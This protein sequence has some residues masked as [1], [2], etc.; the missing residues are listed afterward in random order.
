MNDSF[1]ANAPENVGG[2]RL[3]ARLLVYPPEPAMRPVFRESTSEAVPPADV[4]RSA[5]RQYNRKWVP[6]G[7]ANM[8]ATTVPIGIGVLCATAGGL[9]F[10]H[11][12]LGPDHYVPFIAMSRAGGWSLM[13]TTVITILCG[14]GHVLS[15]VVLGVAGIAVGIAVFKLETIEGLRGELAG[16]LLLAFGLA[17]LTWGVHRAV[18]NRPHTHRH[19]HADGTV[20]HHTHRHANNHAHAHASPYAPEQGGPGAERAGGSMTP[21]ILF[22]IFVFGPCEP[23]I[24]CV[25]YP[26]AQGSVWGVALVTLVFGTITLATMTTIVVLAYLGMT[27]FTLGRFQRYSHAAA[28]LLLVTCGAA[29]LFGL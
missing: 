7:A 11:T 17:Y 25:M 12:L 23:L 28:G 5:T 24:P 16:W 26:A 6:Y 19:A 20:H 13:K 3:L 8:E 15:S 1:F 9:G 2:H 27:R 22:T 4:E 14:L 10:M 21:W 18:R 29:M